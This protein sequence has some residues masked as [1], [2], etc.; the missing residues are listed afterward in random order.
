MNNYKFGYN[1]FCDSNNPEP[2]NA[3]PKLNKE[4]L[5]PSMFNQPEYCEQ[6]A[7]RI[8]F[9]SEVN[10]STILTLNKTLRD[11]SNSIYADVII[12]NIKGLNIYL[13]INSP[14]GTATDG[15]SAMDEINSSI[16]DIYTIVDG[17]CASAATLLSMVGKKRLIKPNSFMLI[18]QLSG[19]HYGNYS[20][21]TDEYINSTLL[22]KKI[23]KA[24]EEHTKIPKKTLNKILKRDL[25]F[26]AKT[27]L[28]YGLVDEII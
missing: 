2:G 27:C 1:K 17:Y 24:Y 3:P 21:L 28:K 18:H 26:D 25:Y 10:N 6:S 7:N 15:F 22:M 12:R 11:L 14:G 4:F 5:D 19:W 8:Y 16:V 9:Y 23:K 13:H 20:Q